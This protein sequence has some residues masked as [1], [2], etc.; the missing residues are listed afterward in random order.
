MNSAERSRF[1]GRADAGK[2]NMIHIRNSLAKI[3]TLAFSVGA[4]LPLFAFIFAVSEAGSVFSAARNALHPLCVFVSSRETHFF[5]CDASGNCVTVT[6]F[7]DC[8][9]IHSDLFKP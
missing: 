6:T 9:P 1:W 4:A 8:P 2:E 5:S 3:V 7:L